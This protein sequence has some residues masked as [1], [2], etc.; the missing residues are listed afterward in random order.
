MATVD[1]SPYNHQ[2]GVADPSRDLGS[3][4][5]QA[6][7]LRRPLRPP[8]RA[9]NNLRW[10]FNRARPP[11][12]LFAVG[13]PFGHS[14]PATVRAP[15]SRGYPGEERICHQEPGAIRPAV[16]F[17]VRALYVLLALRSTLPDISRA[18]ARR[19]CKLLS[20]KCEICSESV[21]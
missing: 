5:G 19:R 6:L 11:R 15:K 14:T 17:P 8:K 10:V 20:E 21:R 12:T 1:N 4:V 16:K 9:F 13:S 2:P 18:T 7:G 3:G